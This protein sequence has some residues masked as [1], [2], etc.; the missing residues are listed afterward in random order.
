MDVN[1]KLINAS[2]VC[3]CAAE[4]TEQVD[5][6]DYQAIFNPWHLIKDGVV[7]GFPTQTAVA[8]YL[9]IRRKALSQ[10]FNGTNL[11]LEKNGYSLV[12]LGSVNGKVRIKKIGGIK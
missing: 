1:D 9:G 10:S 4:R 2:D 11:W 3:D 7:T 6:T 5:V 8:E 12:K